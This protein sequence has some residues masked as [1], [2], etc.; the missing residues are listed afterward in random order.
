MT[1]L[2]E[3]LDAADPEIDYFSQ[4]CVWGGKSTLDR[5]RDQKWLRKLWCP[6]LDQNM[7]QR[8]LWQINCVGQLAQ[9][10]GCD[11]LIAPGGS[12]YSSFRPIV[13]ISQNLLPF[14]FRE[15]RRYGFSWMLVRLLLLRLSQ[16]SSFRRS[17]GVIFLTDYARDSVQKVTGKLGGKIITIPHGVN[18]R[19]RLSPSISS[20]KMAPIVYC[21]PRAKSVKLVY[22]SVVDQYK[23]Q[24]HVIEGV[25]LAR[26]QTGIDFQLELVGP[27]YKP[28]LRRLRGALA[29]HDPAGQWAHY[30]GAADYMQI[31]DFYRSSHIGIWASTCEAFGMILLEMMSVGMP[32]ISSN[33][34]PMAEILGDAGIYFDPELPE[35]LACA[36]LQ[37]M[38]SE[39]LGETLAEFACEKAAQYSWVGCARSTFRFLRE[40][41]ECHGTH[42][43]GKLCVE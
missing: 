8:V 2:K 15:M 16:A 11:L 38:E 17:D 29:R 41:A 12:F 42:P 37:L 24:W 13:T 9:S 7:F 26:D 4:I 32:I 23:H 25:S 20:S 6:A 39:D 5:L 40:V 34:G 36:L 10:E 27:A 19:F 28:A 21:A 14:E 3:L 43:V 31:H 22:V 35:T 30:R 33:S 18:C 1:H